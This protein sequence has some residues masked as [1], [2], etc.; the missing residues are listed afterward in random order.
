MQIPNHLIWVY[1]LST[2][3]KKSKFDLDKILGGDL[4]YFVDSKV[5]L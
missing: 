5:F 4:D 1:H 2:S 3:V